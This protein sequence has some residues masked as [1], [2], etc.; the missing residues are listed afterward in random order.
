MRPD[1]G[2][3]I[4][5]ALPEHS[6]TYILQTLNRQFQTEVGCGH[7]QVYGETPPSP[8]YPSWAFPAPAKSWGKKKKKSLK[9]VP[10]KTKVLK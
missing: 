6:G 4:Q 3:D 2:L 1:G 9:N 10:S 7:M 5:G 8:L